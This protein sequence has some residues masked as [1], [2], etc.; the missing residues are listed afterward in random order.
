LPAALFAAMG[1]AVA[2]L[3]IGI[4]IGIAIPRSAVTGT[5]ERSEPKVR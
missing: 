2:D 3:L 5:N 1:G 4:A